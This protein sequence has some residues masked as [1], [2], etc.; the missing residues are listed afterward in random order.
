MVTWGTNTVHTVGGSGSAP[1]P[2]PT[3][4]S[5]GSSSS[6]APS[7]AAGGGLF[8]SS[9]ST[10]AP[11]FSFAAPAPSGSSFG[12]SPT[13]AAGGFFTSPAPAPS[14]GFF[15][16]SAST[17]S[18]TAFGSS[19][20]LSG[21]G[22]FGSTPAPG[23][24]W[25][26]AAAPPPFGASALQQ[27]QQ[28]VIPAQAAIQAHLN[29][30]AIQEEQRVSKALQ[31][32]Q[33]AYE[34]MAPA[35][36]TKSAPFTS[37]V[38]NASTSQMRQEQLIRGIGVDGTTPPVAPPK[39]P[40]ISENDWLTAVVRNPDNVNLMPIPLIGATA[41][42]A[43]S[44]SH[45]EHVNSYIGQLT[46]I[47]ETQEKL[48]EHYEGTCAQLDSIERTYAH[49]RKK[50]LSVMKKVELIRCLHYPL[51]QD[52][53]VVMSKLKR[54][55][56]HI[57]HLQHTL[58]D[59]MDDAARSQQPLR[60]PHVSDMPDPEQLKTILMQHRNALMQLTSIVQ[61]DS[62]DLDLIKNRLEASPKVLVPRSLSSG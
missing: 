17:T 2:A 48:Q 49:L 54:L 44:T 34:G 46:A 42:L 60:C 29:A 55:V 15:G 32:V 38:Y 20:S 7:S 62:R 40:Q 14:S 24:F 11:S 3:G 1:T 53:I 4:F 58:S 6:P 30:T 10:P 12:Q 51:Q 47:E 50:L 37:I 18:G 16:T 45:Q 59:W 52:E 23:G 28:P 19:P 43:R 22:I 33:S 35:T 25:G 57:A 31:H 61:R 21:G 13:P 8:G 9:S 56:E 5:F 39:P 36:D 41:L 27:Q 26:T